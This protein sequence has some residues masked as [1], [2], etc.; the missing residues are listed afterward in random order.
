MR[1]LLLIER[2]EVS[3]AVKNTYSS[4]DMFLGMFA[5]FMFGVVVGYCKGRQSNI[6]KVRS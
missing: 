4:G 5:G 2:Q 3:A 1:D 6:E